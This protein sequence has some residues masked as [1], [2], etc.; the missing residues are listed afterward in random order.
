METAEA[1]SSA[2][3]AFEA[4]TVDLWYTLIFPTVA[5]RHRIE[6]AR[7][8]VWS[9]A[10]Q[11]AG[12]SPRR[13]ARWARLIEE[14]A[15]EAEENGF[16]PTWNER[17]DR[18]SRRIQVPLDAQDLAARFTETVPLTQVRVAPGAPESLARLREDGIRLGIV[19]N[20][21]HEP[22]E[23]VRRLLRAHDLD[24]PFDCVVLSTDVG[25][26]KP[27]REPYDRAL[28]LLGVRPGGS[29]HVGDAEADFRGAIAAGV[30]PL[31]YTGL[32]RWKPER[33]RASP[34]AWLSKVMR[35]HRWEEVPRACGFFGALPPVPR[36]S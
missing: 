19:S 21:T 23:A 16:S 4:L 17:V 30:H 32:R 5:V 22:P 18:W 29:V 12:C 3:R 6:S 15:D 27:R 2:P 35:V 31:L 24:T 8:S 11:E 7:R 36:P 33:L 34:P 1:A 14:N 13:S 28:E 20:A 10:L 25:R 26:A 9:E